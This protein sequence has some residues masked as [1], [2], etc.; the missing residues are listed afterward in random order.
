M[1]EA[2]VRIA[3]SLSYRVLWD[4]N[5]AGPHAARAVELRT[6]YLGPEHP[7]TLAALS[8]QALV[9]R[10]GGWGDRTK[11]ESAAAIARRVL[12]GRR[13]ALGPAHPDTLVSQS[14]LAFLLIRLGRLDEALAEAEQAEAIALRTLGPDHQTTLD[15][16]YGLGLVV[17]ARGDHQRGMALLRRVVA[18][19]E[20]FLGPLDPTTIEAMLHLAGQARE[21]GQLQEAQRLFL[22][23]VDRLGRVYGLSH[24][25]CSNPMNLLIE[26]LRQQGDYAAIRDLCEQWL[27][28]ILA[29]PVE[30]DP[31]QRSRRAVRL[32]WLELTLTTLP[33]QVGFD[34]DL[35]VRAGKESA[36][37]K[38]G[39]G[40]WMTLGALH[41]RTGRLDEALQAFQAATQQPNWANGNDLYWFVL[42]ATYARRGELAR[43]AECYKRAEA[44][45]TRHDNWI[46]IT[47]VFRAEAAAL[48]G[49]DLSEPEARADAK[50]AR[51]SK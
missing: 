1:V 46:N 35:A 33:A 48:L 26:V 28:E 47:D 13:R 24:I 41:Y 2:S 12:A 18:G 42:A 22:D 50:P 19:R 34:A 38:P 3:L 6:R 49:I 21:D 23:V 4:L 43:A 11:W 40:D 37:L 44:P 51:P 45:D 8:E 32:S 5:R 17:G 14:D 27:R 10:D 7:E 15:V 20:Q 25:G 30:P 36:T 31:D 16:W 39:W 29:S 9:L